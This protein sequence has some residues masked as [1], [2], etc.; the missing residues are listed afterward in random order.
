MVPAL[1]EAGA[2]R[3]AGRGRAGLRG[4]VPGR[5][6]REWEAARYGHVLRELQTLIRPDAINALPPA[7]DPRRE[8][9]WAPI[10]A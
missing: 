4:R 10:R 8:F 5:A 6:P 3:R 2:A 7:P 9:A 1:R